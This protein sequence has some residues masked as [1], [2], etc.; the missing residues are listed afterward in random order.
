MFLSPELDHTIR[1]SDNRRSRESLN[2][3]YIIKLGKKRNW[4]VV[5]FLAKESLVRLE[6][7]GE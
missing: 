7:G 2:L 5:F 4:L 3:E 1:G 6:I